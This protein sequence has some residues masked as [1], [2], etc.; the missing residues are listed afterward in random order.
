MAVAAVE[1][2]LCRKWNRAYFRPGIPVLEL[3]WLGFMFLC[4][5][6][7]MAGGLVLLTGLILELSAARH[8]IHQGPDM[9]LWLSAAVLITWLATILLGRR[10]QRR[11]E[12]LDPVE[13][14]Q[15]LG[16]EGKAGHPSLQRAVLT[17]RY[18]RIQSPEVVRH[19]TLY[20]ASLLL[21]FITFGLVVVAMIFS[22][23]PK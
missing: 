15:L 19:C 2:I 3:L 20:R 13:R 8:I 1:T 7:W 4:W 21:Y 10:L 22:F 11:V 6:S 23:F 12:A 14:E 5:W 9:I 17:G 18:R 16:F